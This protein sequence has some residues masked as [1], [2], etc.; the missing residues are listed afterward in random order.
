MLAPPFG[1]IVPIVTSRSFTVD[2]L[3]ALTGPQRFAR[4]EQYFAE[5]RVSQLRCALDG[6]A[7]VVRDGGD[8]PVQLRWEDG[9]LVGGCDCQPGADGGDWCEHAVAVALAWLDLGPQDTAEESA[10]SCDDAELTGFLAAQES[11]WLAEQLARIAEEDP[12]IWVRLAAA[13]GSDAA[14]IECRDLLEEAVLGY[15]PFA[16]NW[17]PRL[18]DGSERLRRAIGLLEDLL[19]YGFTESVAEL[20]RDV[21]GLLE[22]RCG[23]M[24][25]EHADRLAEIADAAR[26][27]AEH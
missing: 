20:A 1:A 14:V 3:A 6:A 24:D 18:D 15:E 5:G 21:A 12:V 25:D 11:A 4:G 23:G 27:I 22:Q 2:D 8:H 9:G 17:G 16:Q 19:D 7:A 10:A 13:A 26:G